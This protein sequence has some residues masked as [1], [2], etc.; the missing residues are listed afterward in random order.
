[1]ARVKTF[2]S[3]GFDVLEQRGIAVR[4]MTRTIQQPFIVGTLLALLVS[5]VSLPALGEIKIECTGRNSRL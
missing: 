2:S 1:M 3:G 4:R 5:V